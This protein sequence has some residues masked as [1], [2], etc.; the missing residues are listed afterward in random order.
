MHGSHWPRAIHSFGREA[1]A[2]VC[3]RCGV[4]SDDPAASIPCSSPPPSDRQ[5]RDIERACDAAWSSFNDGAESMRAAVKRELERS[6][7]LLREARREA[8]G[9]TA[10]EDRVLTYFE[11]ILTIIHRRVDR[12]RVRADESRGDE[13]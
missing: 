1:P 6:V 8:P 12:I 3:T 4:R 9:L 7:E 10:T 5:I 13:R 11:S 2:A